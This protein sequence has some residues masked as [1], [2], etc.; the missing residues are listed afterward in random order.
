M[1]YN[2]FD[3]PPDTLYLLERFYL[4][5]RLRGNI[6][7][8]N[9]ECNTFQVSE[10]GMEECGMSYIHDAKE[11]WIAQLEEIDREELGMDASQ[12]SPDFFAISHWSLARI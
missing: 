6:L 2:L 1:A 5:E 8:S 4:L 11:F 7:E 10:N 9:G 3:T 12:R